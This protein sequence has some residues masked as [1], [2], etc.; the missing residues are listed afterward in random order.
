[1][2]TINEII[3]E[4]SD[5][6]KTGFSFIDI[7]EEF[8]K[9]SEEEKRLPEFNYETIAV[10]LVENSRNEHWGTYYGPYLQLKDK[11]NINIDVPPYESITV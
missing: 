2:K 8:S 11:D 4:Y 10:S 5:I 9:V 1:M 3:S 7:S 6:N